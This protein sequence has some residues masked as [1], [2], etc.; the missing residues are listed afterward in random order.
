MKHQ[1]AEG[2]MDQALVDLGRLA[3][4]LSGDETSLKVKCLLKVILSH[5]VVLLP[6]Q[7]QYCI[8]LTGTS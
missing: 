6:E 2:L 1:K 4:E 8:R 7:C 3:H 5:Y